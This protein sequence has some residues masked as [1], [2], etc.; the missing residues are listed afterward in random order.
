MSTNTH[1]FSPL[2]SKMLCIPQVTALDGAVEKL[3]V[4][5]FNKSLEKAML[6]LE[7]NKWIKSGEGITYLK[8]VAKL[9][10]ELAVEQ[11]YGLKKAQYGLYIRVAKATERIPNV[12]A[13]FLSK[14]EAKLGAASYNLQAFDDYVKALDKVVANPLPSTEGSEGGEG[15]DT[16]EGRMDKVDVNTKPIVTFSYNGK[17]IG[18]NNV[19]LKIDEKHK[20]KTSSSIEDV[21][22]AIAYLQTA[23]KQLKAET[24]AKVAVKANASLDKPKAAKVSKFKIKPTVSVDSAVASF[25]AEIVSGA[26]L[27]A[28]ELMAAPF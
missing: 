11:A 26:P 10:Q 19:S 25:E 21:E 15:E 28:V 17:A 14:C 3:Q 8:E 20:L 27:D 24:A 22:T 13:N 9:T 12:V 2:A 4:K 6:L 23:L 1:K 16:T 7:G 5:Q 18:G